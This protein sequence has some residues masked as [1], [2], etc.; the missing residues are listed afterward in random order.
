M[1]IMHERSWKVNTSKREARNPRLGEWEGVGLNLSGFQ[2]LYLPITFGIFHKMQI[3]IDL[4]FK[5]CNPL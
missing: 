5:V 2:L 3:V 1:N 4:F